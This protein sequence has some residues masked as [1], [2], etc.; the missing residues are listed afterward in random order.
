MSE[1]NLI[2]EPWI[3]CTTHDGGHIEYGLFDT[4]VKSNQIREIFDESPLV[5]VSVLRLLLAVLYRAHSGIQ[6][7]EDWKSLYADGSFDTHAVKNYLIKWKERFFLLDAHHPFYQMARLKTKSESKVT[8]LV[9]AVLGSNAKDA[10]VRVGGDENE[11]WTPAR[12]AL[13]LV[14][15]QAYAS[16]FGKSAEA[17]IG[18][19]I[20]TR[21]HYAD[22]MGLGGVN[23]WIQGRNLFET[24]MMN[25]SPNKE[26]QSRPPWEMDDGHQFMD[27][28]TEQGI[29]KVPSFGVVDQLTWQSRL[30]RLLGEAGKI[31][32]M[33]F[34]QGRAADK[35]RYDPMK[36]YRTSKKAY[37][38]PMVLKKNESIWRHVPEI[39]ATQKGGCRPVCFEVSSW[40]L[41]NNLVQSTTRLDVHILRVELGKV[42]TSKGL[43]WRHEKISLPVLLFGN[44]DIL[45]RLDV[46]IQNAEHVGEELRKRVARVVKLSSKSNA[47]MSGSVYPGKTKIAKIVKNIDPRADFWMRLEKHFSG[48]V[49]GLVSEWDPESHAWVPPQ[50][51]TAA[52]IWQ[53][54]V[55]K[56]ARMAFEHSTRVLGRSLD[57]MNTGLHESNQLDEL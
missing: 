16:G 25:L 35:S 43:D 10:F 14:T 29:K 8:R 27:V 24:L 5:V 17:Q 34:T 46:S 39:F 56:E 53:K 48:L 49:D 44:Q 4:L 22:A 21:P 36:I 12:T 7:F 50:R 40:A 11:A 45:D 6:L 26:D 54:S 18:G 3:P 9:S 13:W 33:Y 28:V 57:T 47:E 30:V 37:E 23:V 15:C 19:K 42:K 31:S 2:D 41:A 32:K 38:S 55:M 52:D 20:V 1:F 51:Q